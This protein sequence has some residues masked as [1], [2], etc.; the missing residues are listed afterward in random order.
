MK[1]SEVQAG[2]R[3]TVKKIDVDRGLKLRLKGMG[4]FE[5]GEFTL[6]RRSATALL[7]E[8]TGR[9][10]IRIETAE[11]IEVEVCAT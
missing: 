8:C 7:V 5:G 6:V 3:A 11:A 9:I 1:L 4:F 2:A 10:S